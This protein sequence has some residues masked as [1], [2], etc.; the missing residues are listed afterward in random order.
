[1]TQTFEKLAPNRYRESFGR[2]FEDFAVGE[3]L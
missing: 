1:M 3:H 2:H